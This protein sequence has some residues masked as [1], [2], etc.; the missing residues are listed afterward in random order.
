MAR[1]DQ[2]QAEVRRVDFQPPEEIE[3]FAFHPL[4]LSTQRRR[5]PF[6]GIG[7]RMV[8][9]S[10]F[11]TDDGLKR[12]VR[13]RRDCILIS[14]SESLQQLTGELAEVG[15]MFSLN[16]Q[17]ETPEAAEDDIPLS[18]GLHAKCYVIDNGWKASIWT[19]SAN[20]TE[21]AF[22]GNIEFLVELMGPKSKFGVDALLRKEG[23]QDRV[24]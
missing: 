24:C 23:R 16:E 3:D 11:V 13:D 9:I 19:G 7:G 22:N 4:G 18:R 8:V 6:E 20:A 2:M 14:R 5:V 15:Q 10:P 21:Q 12:L 17:A 1:I